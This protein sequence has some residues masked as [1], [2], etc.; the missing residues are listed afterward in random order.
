MG[1]K[2]GLA[3][4]VIIGVLVAAFPLYVSYLSSYVWSQ[5]SYTGRGEESR[6]NIHTLE[7][8][9]EKVY[10]NE[11]E[12]EVNGIVLKVNGAWLTSNGEVISSS[13]LLQYLKSAEKV[14]V[15][16]GQR[17]RWG[18]VLEEIAI[19]DTGERYTRTT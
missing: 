19:V 8:V 5:T 14:I 12:I 9:I 16:Y 4:S 3:I 18:S 17:G 1:Y 7:G 13:E 11:S 6:E 15:K 10:S 2:L